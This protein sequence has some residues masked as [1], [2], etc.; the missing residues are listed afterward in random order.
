MLESTEFELCYSIKHSIKV[1]VVFIYNNYK[2]FCVLMSDEM[3]MKYIL[4]YHKSLSVHSAVNHTRQYFST[5][6]LHLI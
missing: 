4:V 1:T 5:E 3:T 2:Y 6:Q